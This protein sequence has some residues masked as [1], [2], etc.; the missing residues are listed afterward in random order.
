[1]LSRN[2]KQ[3]SD[4][5]IIPMVIKSSAVDRLFFTGRKFT[6]F[7][8]KDNLYL[9]TR[10][11]FSKK[12]TK[13]NLTDIIDVKF[14]RKFNGIKSFFAGIFYFILIILSII[15]L[16]VFTRGIHEEPFGFLKFFIPFGLFICLIKFVRDFYKKWL[17][18]ITKQKVI[19]V[20]LFFTPYKN[21][22]RFISEVKLTGKN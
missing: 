2:N 19:K 13:I 22:V 16:H 9:L 4:V 10:S 5:N 1:M 14:Q 12:E 8:Q 6:I 20:D 3:K 21:V 7:L 11:L 15:I 17:I 18:I